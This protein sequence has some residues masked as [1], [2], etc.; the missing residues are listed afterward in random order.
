[1]T[2]DKHLLKII[3]PYCSQPYTAIMLH[4]LWFSEGS[5]TPDCVGSKIGSSIEITCTHCGKLVYKKE[6]SDDIDYLEWE[7]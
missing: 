1:M 3:C 4:K 7:K 6:I 2:Y 5:Y